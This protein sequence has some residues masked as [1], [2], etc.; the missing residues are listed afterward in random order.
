MN[1]HSHKFKEII[2]VLSCGV[3]PEVAGDIEKQSVFVSPFIERIYVEPDGNAVRI[4]TR[5]GADLVEVEAK[6][7]RFLEVMVRQVTGFEVKV[8][9]ANK[10]RDS[11]P[12]HYGVND[13]LVKRGWMYDYGKGQVAYSGPVLKLAG[14]INDK[15]GELYKSCLL[16]TSD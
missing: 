8:S 14:L 16:Y 1:H 7:K 13:E 12:Y 9:M 2:V 5:N 11:G 3:D 15:T 4:I 10:R 6:A